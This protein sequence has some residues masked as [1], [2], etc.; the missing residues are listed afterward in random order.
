MWAVSRKSHQSQYIFRIFLK[1]LRI[2]AVK[3]HICLIDYSCIPGFQV[4]YYYLT[5]KRGRGSL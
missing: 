4:V 1:E 5:T 3:W 2:F